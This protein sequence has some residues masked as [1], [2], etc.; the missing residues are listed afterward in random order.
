MSNINK[1]DSDDIY[2]RTVQ[3]EYTKID[4]K[5][6]QLHYKTAVALVIVAFLVEVSMGIFLINSDMLRTTVHR[7][8][9]KYLIFPSGINFI[10]I[11]LNMFI[12]KSKIFSQTFKIYAI[13]IIFVC[14]NFVLFAVHNAFIAIYYIA[15]IAIMLTIIYANYYVTGMTALTSIVSMVISEL[16]IQWDGD[17]ISIFQNTLRF[18]EF[19]ISLISLITFSIA[20]MIIIRFE[21]KKNSVSIQKEIERQQLQQIL[22]MDEMTGIYNRKALHN[23]LKHVEDTPSDT[24][25]ILAIVDI[26]RFK[27][28]NDTWGHHIGDRC[29]IEFAKILKEYHTNITPFRYG[30]DEFCLL[31]RGIRM[32][33]AEIICREIQ[34]KVNN[35]AFKDYPK[36]ELTVSFGLAA[37]SDQIDTVRLFINADH[38]LYEA[39]KVRN[40]ICVFK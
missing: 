5:W 29:L 28:I 33:D 36:L 40:S 16:F 15:A 25:H 4:G 17:K 32:A 8:F 2:I 12:I 3:K 6:L 24:Q 11:A 38:A 20:C 18:S 26:D 35:L 39:K 23:E 10:F 21:R 9:L 13:S 31:F 27:S 37:I 34:D 14:I 22:H 1:E 7:F 30:G 19:L